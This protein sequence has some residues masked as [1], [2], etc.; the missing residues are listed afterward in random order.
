MPLLDTLISR[1]GSSIIESKVKAE[2]ERIQESI[3]RQEEGYRRL[4]A[5]D[6][7]D[8]TPITHEK[9]LKL[10]YYLYLSNPLARRILEYTKVYVVGK[11]I[12]VI[13]EDTN[14]NKIVQNYWTDTDNNWDLKQG[15][16]VLELG[17]FGEQIYP[18]FVAPNGHVKTGFIDPMKVAQVR[19]DIE[20][21]E[22]KVAVEVYNQWSAEPRVY[23][24]IRWD[25]KEKRYYPPRDPITGLAGTFYF[26]VNSVTGASRGFSDLLSL[27]DWIDAYDQIVFKF[28]ERTS[29]I[30]Q[31]IYD[32]TLKGAGAAEVR[33]RQ[34]DIDKLRPKAGAFVVHSDKEEWEAV[35]PDLRARENI[36]EARHIK[37]I[38][39]AGAGYPEF[40]FAEGEM[41][42]RA[43]ALAQGAPT[44][45][46]LLERQ[47]YVKYMI[48]EIIK[49]VIWQAKQNQALNK[50]A[51]DK[52]QVIMPDLELI[53]YTTSAAALASVA[54]ALSISLDQNLVTTETAQAV[55]AFSIGKL[56]LEVDSK[57]ELKKLKEI[58][59]EIGTKDPS[60]YD[61]L[62]KYLK[63]KQAENK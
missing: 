47:T 9:H 25:D 23:P 35:T 27:E 10:A 34:K 61:M 49:Y 28:V 29:L 57:A 12:K 39:L 5:Q 26:D 37:N 22:R 15:K 42:T 48:T 54:T 2:V 46:V 19:L 20:N 33:K 51:S 63:L 21:P 55:F 11:G 4:T 7:R 31:F 41:T 30:Q 8:L 58:L 13:A 6:Y 59:S 60:I 53:E 36:E 3:D 32:V 24:I 43:T 52:F 50:D 16:R 45:K 17:L 18:A 14:T 62:D 38:I 56:G 1:I 44:Y 40:F